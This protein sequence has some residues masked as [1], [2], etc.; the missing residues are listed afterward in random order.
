MRAGEW[1]CIT[2]PGIARDGE[3]HTFGEVPGSLGRGED[4]VAGGPAADAL[5]AKVGAVHEVVAR[6]PRGRAR[7]GCPG[8]G[9]TQA[10]KG[11]SDH[12][13]RGDGNACRGH[14][15]ESS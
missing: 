6:T 9:G 13:Y 2:A 14:E 4:H 12:E 10:S 3:R 11:P 7:R 8:A 5:C 1:T 15:R